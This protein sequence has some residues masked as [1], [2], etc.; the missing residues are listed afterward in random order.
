[1]ATL[2]A[3]VTR[4]TAVWYGP[5]KGPAV[6][7]TVDIGGLGLQQGHVLARRILGH[8]RYLLLLLRRDHHCQS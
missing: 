1:M 2:A 3:E 7:P 8:L 4:S 6:D 5:R